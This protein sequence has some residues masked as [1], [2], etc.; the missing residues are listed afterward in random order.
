MTVTGS[1]TSNGVTKSGVDCIDILILLLKPDLHETNFSREANFSPG[2]FACE[3]AANS[4]FNFHCQ[5]FFCEFA[6]NNAK[7][8]GICSKTVVI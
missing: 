7:E 6:E 3:F 8:Q 1:V 4:K 5:N 2:I